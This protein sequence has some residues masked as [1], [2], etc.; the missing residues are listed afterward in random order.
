MHPAI[1]PCVVFAGIEKCPQAFGLSLETHRCLLLREASARLRNRDLD[2]G[3]M[4]SV[5]MSVGVQET[6]AETEAKTGLDRDIQELF[7]ARPMRAV[8]FAHDDLSA[9]LD[10]EGVTHAYSFDAAME[11]PLINL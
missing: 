10:L 4:A 6:D 1:F 8:A 11:G 2:P 7:Q 5:A 3:V 9:F